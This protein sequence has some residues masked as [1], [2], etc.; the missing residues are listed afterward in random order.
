MLLFSIT[1][2]TNVKAMKCNPRSTI[3]FL[4]GLT[5]TSL[6]LAACGLFGTNDDPDLVCTNTVLGEW[7]YLG[8]GEK[9]SWKIRE[10]VF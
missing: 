8:V 1:N 2:K 10:S 9:H 6:F 5:I 7:P 4:F 3:L